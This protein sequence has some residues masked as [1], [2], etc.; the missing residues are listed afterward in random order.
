ME[1][2]DEAVDEGEPAAGEEV[3]TEQEGAAAE[4][5][6]HH[7]QLGEPYHPRQKEQLQR[8]QATNQTKSSGTT[9][10]IIVTVVDGTSPTGTPAT[11][12]HPII[13][14]RAIK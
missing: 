4:Y 3:A 2:E 14:R 5:P 8:E 12:A 1:D 6:H 11:R 13:K 7:H 10:G 9:I